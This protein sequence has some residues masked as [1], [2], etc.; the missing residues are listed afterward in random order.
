MKPSPPNR[1]TPILRWNAMPTD[2]AARGAQER[3]LLADQ[4]AAERLQIH[5]DDLA[6]IRRAERD[7]MLAAALVGEDRHEQAL[8]GQDALAGAPAARRARRRLLLRAV[9]EDRFELDAVGH[10]HHDAGFGDRRLARIELDL[11]ELHLVAVDHEVDVVRAAAGR[12]RRRRHRA[13]AAAA[14]DERRER[15]HVLDL[16]PVGHARREHQRLGVD[17]AVAEV[18]DDLVLRHRPDLMAAD[19]HVPLLRSVHSLSPEA[20]AHASAVRMTQ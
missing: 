11:D 5:R 6:G 17:A 4:L 19:G 18:G 3:V 8:T 12:G 13:A 10:V 14:A 15:R 20:A 16:L 9:A 1:P 7:A 2:D